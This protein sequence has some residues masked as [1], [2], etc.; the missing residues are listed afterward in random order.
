MLQTQVMTTELR[1]CHKH[2]GT[3]Y[4]YIIFP[5]QLV[6][7]ATK[8]IYVDGVCFVHGKHN[9]NGSRQVIHPSSLIH[10]Q[11]EV[12]EVQNAMVLVSC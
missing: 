12:R 7:H 1:L 8:T 9:R 2:L 6:Q 11:K 4:D 5:E 10:L 3:P